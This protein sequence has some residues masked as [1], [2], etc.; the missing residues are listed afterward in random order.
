MTA[1]L[2]LSY[3][4]AES[5]WATWQWTDRVGPEAARLHP[6]VL[7]V[8]P[9]AMADALPGASV[10]ESI[11]DAVGRTL[12]GPLGDPESSAAFTEQL[13]DALIPGPL[14]LGLLDRAQ[15]EGARPRLRIQPSPSLAQVPWPLLRVRLSADGSRRSL[16]TQI[17]DLCL[18]VPRDAAADALPP[19][20]GQS[21]VMVI[22]PRVPGYSADSA[23]G[24]V[25]GRPRP[26]DLL[27]LLTVRHAG[28]LVPP[29]REYPELVRRTDQDRAWLREA[30]RGAGRF[31]YLGHVS[32]AG[33][34]EATGA[35]SS[36]HLTCTDGSGRHMA[37]RAADIIADPDLRFPARVA[38]LGCGSGTDLRYPE[39]MGLSI[40]A[41]L[42]GARLVTSSM[43]TLPTDAAIE[44]EPLRRLTLAVDD[45]HEA[46]DPV[47]A[48]TA[49]QAE[50]GDAWFAEGAP[51]DSPLL[52][53]ATMTHVA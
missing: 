29:V 17:A 50:R 38:L 16:L 9:A 23:L 19:R 45:A 47:A 27:A 6:N 28:R 12:Q 37:L 5:C 44:G 21:V 4:E 26:D 34:A 40:A 25:L 7:S 31:L 43:W 52:W 8:I 53:A 30:L 35:S 48:L 10:G 33:V 49:W 39:P 42:K 2:A 51:A 22:D 24:S 13:A 18:G 1:T 11:A 46:A 20:T 32:A 14:V 41:V 3:A 36:L 15:R